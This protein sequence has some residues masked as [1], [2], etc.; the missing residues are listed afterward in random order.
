MTERP[1]RSALRTM[2]ISAAAL[3]A[4]ASP[5]KS[6]AQAVAPSVPQ[7]PAAESIHAFGNRSEGP[8][9]S[10]VSGK[11]PLGVD[12]KTGELIYYN[13]S[14]LDYYRELIDKSTKAEQAW[15]QSE[16]HSRRLI[17]EYR[18]SGH[19]NARLDSYIHFVDTLKKSKLDIPSKVEAVNTYVNEMLSYDF[20]RA[21][22]KDIN[23]QTTYQSITTGLV[24]CRDLTHL[25]YEML[26]DV[27]VPEKD[28]RIVDGVVQMPIAEKV[29]HSEGHSVLMVNTN[30]Y[31]AILDSATTDVLNKYNTNQAFKS[32]L[33]RNETFNED[34]QQ[35]F[36]IVGHGAGKSYAYQLKFGEPAVVASPPKY[37]LGDHTVYI[38]W[39]E[40]SGN[41]LSMEINGKA[42]ADKTCKIGHDIYDQVKE[43]HGLNPTRTQ[44][45]QQPRSR[46]PL[47][48]PST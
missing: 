1:N 33:V 34:G 5:M 2:A 29:A 40:E 35:F 22:Q 10:V 48:S 47:P 28:M 44:G 39:D 42:C 30:G 23:I 9:Q 46:P 11:T 15:Q 20:K 43:A 31:N 36:P 24:V 26:K 32:G 17:D 19:G 25:K 38:T 4:A 41:T 6:A 18:H 8:L 14:G 21:E 3:A 12:V 45:S 37:R 7:A 16:K 27:G 13:H